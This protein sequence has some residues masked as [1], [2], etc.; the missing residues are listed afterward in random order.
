LLLP[1]R[2]FRHP[3]Y[4]SSKQATALPATKVYTSLVQPNIT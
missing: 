4:R 1:L 3:N 2:F